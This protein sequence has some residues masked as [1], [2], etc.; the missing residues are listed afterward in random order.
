VA[1]KV[2]IPDGLAYLNQKPERVKWKI[3]AGPPGAKLSV[4]QESDL[5]YDKHDRRIRQLDPI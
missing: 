4:L 2:R 1:G 3:V 5:V